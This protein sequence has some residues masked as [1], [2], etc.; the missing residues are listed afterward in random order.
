M[1][2][3]AIQDH[4][5]SKLAMLLGVTLAEFASRYLLVARKGAAPLFWGVDDGNGDNVIIST[6]PAYLSSFPA[7]CAFEVREPFRWP[8][9]P[10]ASSPAI[11]TVTLSRGLR[12]CERQAEASV[13][14]RRCRAR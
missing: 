5:A 11:I 8:F 1:P 14:A 10:D 6:V 7:G 13:G 2:S 3:V 12:G 9:C 4:T